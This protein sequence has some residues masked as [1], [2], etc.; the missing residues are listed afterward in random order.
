[1]SP[2]QENRRFENLPLG[3]PARRVRI[4]LGRAPI[5]GSSP[6]CRILG[7]EP[8]LSRGWVIDVD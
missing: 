2:P 1:M 4:N 3:A 6:P 8:K 5:R 7:S